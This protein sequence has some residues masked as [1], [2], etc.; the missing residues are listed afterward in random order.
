[1]LLKVYFTNQL[2]GHTL[3]T[4]DI[5][6]ELAQELYHQ[7]FDRALE[8]LNAAR[9]LSTQSLVNIRQAVQTM[10]HS[11]FDLNQALMSLICQFRQNQS[12]SIEYN[13][14]LPQLPLQTSYQLYC[15]IQEALTNIRKH[16]H[17]K[18]V[19]LTSFVTPDTITLELID[20]GIGF[21]LESSHTGF[22]LRGMQER[23]QLLGGQFKIK[24]FTGQGTH[25][26]VTIDR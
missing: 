2:L 19:S 18:V 6:L 9:E 14:N 4:L 23:I 17:A 3:T 24:T 5:Q 13:I 10:R 26:Q 25:L 11:D 7:D 1:L 22:G 8:A 15:V 16:S 12:I 20:D 21:N